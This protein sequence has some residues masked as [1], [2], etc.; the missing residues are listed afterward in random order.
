[1][2]QDA[3]TQWR[4]NAPLAAGLA[5]IAI[6]LLFTIMDRDSWPFSSYP[7]FAARASME[8][9]AYRFEIARPSGQEPFEVQ[10]FSKVAIAVY[11]SALKRQDAETIR[12]FLRE[13]LSWLSARGEIPE[14][15]VSLSLIRLRARTGEPPERET[16]AT[17][18]V[19]TP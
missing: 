12:A 18:P 4:R 3:K 1:M 9:K 15:A 13:Q 10:E 5:L 6:Q 2:A 14:D 7:M 11:D 16:I 17:I 8:L 19:G